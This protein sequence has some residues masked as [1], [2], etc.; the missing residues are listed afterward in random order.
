MNDIFQE[1]ESIKKDLDRL[2]MGL[3]MNAEAIETIEM[4][5]RFLEVELDNQLLN[6]D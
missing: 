2:E 5:I 3:A 6:N 4:D 1:L